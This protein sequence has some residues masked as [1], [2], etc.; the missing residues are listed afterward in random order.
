MKVETLTRWTVNDAAELYGI[1]N[2]GMG[3]FDIN[4]E[5]EVIVRPQ[6]K[7]ASASTSLKTIIA[8]L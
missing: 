7:A 2:W 3:Y 5:G 6:G 8:D 4:E 1:R